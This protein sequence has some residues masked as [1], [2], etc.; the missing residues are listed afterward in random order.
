MQQFN[1]N[2]MEINTQ[3]YAEL[4]T[5]LLSTARNFYLRW[6]IILLHKIAIVCILIY[7][8]WESISDQQSL[9]NVCSQF[10]GTDC[11]SD[12][13]NHSHFE[14]RN[15]KHSTQSSVIVELEPKLMPG[16]W[17]QSYSPTSYSRF[18]NQSKANL[19]PQRPI[20]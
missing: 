9:I 7:Y 3:V 8:A 16:N 12:G 14:D 6:G 1:V 4:R 2:Y 10:N 13:D 17:I 15:D 5:V 20:I 11:Q 18:A 19:K